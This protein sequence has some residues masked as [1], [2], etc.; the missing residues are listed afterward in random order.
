VA[1]SSAATPAAYLAEMEPAQRVLVEEIRRTVLDKL[2]DGYVELM[3]YGMLTYAIPLARF[4][5]TY[6][7]Q[8]LGALSL[9]TE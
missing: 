5:D 9:G 6:S 8:P 3:Q 7:G 2:P 4:A 1:N